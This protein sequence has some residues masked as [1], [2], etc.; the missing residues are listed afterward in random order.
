MTTATVSRGGALR[1]VF[2]DIAD[3][4]AS[5][6]AQALMSVASITIVSG[7]AGHIV[8]WPANIALAVGAEWA[9]LRGIASSG[10]ARGAWVS[11]LN[12]GA[13]GLVVL[14]GLLWSVRGFGTNPADVFGPWGLSMLHIL[15]IAFV[16]LSAAKVHG[17]A[18]QQHATDEAQRADAAHAKQATIEAED[19]ARAHR[20]A[21][22]EDA[23]AARLLDAQ[24][25]IEAE[26]SKA[27]ARLEYRTES[28]RVA[29]QRPHDAGRREPHTAAPSPERAMTKEELYAAV[30]VACAADPQFSR[31]DMARESG[32]S[33][34]M[35]RKAI[36]AQAAD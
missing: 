7:E 5:Q 12:W 23:A 28:A 25:E 26:K 29:A 36:K 15:P 30:R 6:P 13:F 31:A 21:A 24:A 22:A 20:R 16:S 35:V 11:A 33:E 14:Y 8:P 32:W 9:F 27:L 2:A 34:A 4:L 19:R 17:T 1:F 10:K 3:L 18:A